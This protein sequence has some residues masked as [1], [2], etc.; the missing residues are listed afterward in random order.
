MKKDARL[1][2]GIG[3]KAGKKGVNRRTHIADSLKK[4]RT[5]NHINE[6]RQNNLAGPTQRPGV[7]GSQ[8]NYTVTRKTP[9]LVPGKAQKG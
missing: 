5:I 4:D 1:G 2:D 3:T 8:G 9:E 7:D 6:T